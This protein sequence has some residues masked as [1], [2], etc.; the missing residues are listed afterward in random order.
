MHL[1][2]HSNFFVQTTHAMRD[3]SDDANVKVVIRCDGL[4][5]FY[6]TYVPSKSTSSIAGNRL[7]TVRRV[8]ATATVRLR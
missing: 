4:R 8:S 6:A 2:K 3:V 1:V 7:E 5:S